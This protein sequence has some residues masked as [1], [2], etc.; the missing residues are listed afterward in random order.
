VNKFVNESWLVLTLGVVF[1][2]LLAGAQTSL[3]ARIVVNRTR[4]LNEA[5]AQVVPDTQKI[6]ALAVAGYDRDVFRCLD[7][8]GKLAGWAIDAVGMGFADKI[9]LVVGLSPDTTRIVG[10]KVIENVETPGLGNKI[11]EDDWA[12]QYRNLDAGRPVVVHKRPPTAGANEVQAVTGATIS[13]KAVTTI[14]NEA[15][16]RVRP[17]LQQQQ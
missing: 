13:S 2:A 4:A 6:E 8:D 15:L 14:V 1:A 5:V 17:A 3:S 16:A 9:R 7:A 11:S 10:L 12:G